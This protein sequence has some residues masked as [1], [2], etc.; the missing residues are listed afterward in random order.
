MLPKSDS[1]EIAG[2]ENVI[3][4]KFELAVLTGDAEQAKGFISQMETLGRHRK[5]AA[6]EHALDFLIEHYPGVWKK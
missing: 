6:M 4:Q 3:Y 5:A 2:S 1:K